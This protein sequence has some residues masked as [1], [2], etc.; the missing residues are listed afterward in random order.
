M[1]EWHSQC[2]QHLHVWGT[3]KQCPHI[4]LSHWKQAPPSS[5][6]WLLHQS[7]IQVLIDLQKSSRHIGPN[8][9]LIKREFKN[10]KLNYARLHR[11]STTA[12]T[13]S[14]SMHTLLWETICPKYC[15][16]LRKNS[17]FLGLIF[18]SCACSALKTILRCYLCSSSVLEKT[19]TTS[20]K[21]PVNEW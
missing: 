11:H 3:E 16:S 19:K 8:I 7:V 21:T 20:K 10:F 5:Q 18:S 1:W 13:L 12:L 4:V 2:F 14:G 9:A 6:H 15:I 17:L